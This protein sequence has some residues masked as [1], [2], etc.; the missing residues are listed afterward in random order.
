MDRAAF[1]GAQDEEP[2]RQIAEGVETDIAGGRGG[3]RAA[4]GG[5]WRCGLA[6][7]SE[8]EKSKG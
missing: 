2:V 7:G 5:R 3:R 4:L 1:I 6:A 8:G